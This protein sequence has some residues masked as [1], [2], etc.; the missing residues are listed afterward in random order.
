LTRLARASKQTFGTLSKENFSEEP[1]SKDKG[2]H[3]G[4][5]SIGLRGSSIVPA[6]QRGKIIAAWSGL[7]PNQLV[8][9]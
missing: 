1:S 6:T 5:L 2:L 3:S 7:H 8:T 4:L 9:S